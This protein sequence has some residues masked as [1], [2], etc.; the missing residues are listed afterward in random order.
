MPEIEEKALSYVYSFCDISISSLDNYLS[1]LREGSR[2]KVRG[3][4]SRGLSVVSNEIDF[5]L[6][7]LEYFHYCK[8]NREI[9]FT[10]KNILLS[11]NS[12]NE[13]K[14]AADKFIN[15]KNTM[16]SLIKALN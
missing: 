3:Y 13:I 11:K 12:K 15:K 4:L 8:S 16:Q 9:E 7:P 10:I 1:D 14:I 6:K 2:L 5:V